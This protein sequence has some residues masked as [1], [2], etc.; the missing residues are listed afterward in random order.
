MG[1]CENAKQSSVVIY[2]YI[3]KELLREKDERASVV[4][5][6]VI[7]NITIHSLTWALTRRSA[8]WRVIEFIISDI[9]NETK[10]TIASYL[11]HL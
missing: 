11:Y 6:D 8:C 7:N 3:F 10:Q 2:V 9:I 4:T 5:I 1:K